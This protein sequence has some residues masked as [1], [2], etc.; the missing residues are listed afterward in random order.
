MEDML[1]QLEDSSWEQQPAQPTQQAE[2]VEPHS[3]RSA[4]G[5]HGGT[6]RAPSPVKQE[7]AAGSAPQQQHKRSLA[8]VGAD[9]PPP[10]SKFRRLESLLG[11]GNSAPGA[12]AAAT[13]E[14][15]QRNPETVVAAAVVDEEEGDV[16]VVE[17]REGGKLMQLEPQ[18]EQ[19]DRQGDAVAASTGA[20]NGSAG[21][22]VNGRPIH[23]S[24]CG[25]VICRNARSNGK[26]WARM[27]A[28]SPADD[29]RGDGSA[30]N[31][32]AGNGGGG[33][34]AAPRQKPTALGGV[35]SGGDAVP[36]MGDLAGQEAPAL[37]Q[38]Q[39]QLQQ[40]DEPQQEQRGPGLRSGKRAFL[41][42]LPQLVLAGP[43]P[44][45]V[46]WPLVRWLPWPACLLS[47]VGLL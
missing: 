34:S 25:C 10:C 1:D 45:K 5:I 46:C 37:K 14:K 7:G 6:G 21:S 43:S 26:T 40:Q 17:E 2:Q 33:S 24:D 8:E 3:N 11:D 13:E 47:S 22:L 38:E 12:T 9:A 20:A 30:A 31:K 16:P 4:A 15:Q 42:A 44:H 29:D 39:E 23:R 32:A 35:K 36:C 28:P 19:Q 18:Q 41:Q 27:A